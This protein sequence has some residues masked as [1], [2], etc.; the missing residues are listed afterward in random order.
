MAGGESG[1]NRNIQSLRELPD[2][3][4]RDRLIYT[5]A[6]IAVIIT[7]LDPRHVD[8]LAADDPGRALQ[9][10]VM[11]QDCQI[12]VNMLQVF[13]FVLDKEDI[14]DLPGRRVIGR[15]QNGRKG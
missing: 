3:H 6:G 8:P 12:P 4:I 1:R 9:H 11:L 7:I 5:A 15:I 14:R 2:N 10:A 13:T